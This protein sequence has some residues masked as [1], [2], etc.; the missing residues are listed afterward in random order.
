MDAGAIHKRT[1]DIVAG[2]VALVVLTVGMTLVLLSPSVSAPR[3]TTVVAKSAVRRVPSSNRTVV[4]TL[5]RGRKTR[6]VT[7]QSSPIAA[8]PRQVTTTTTANDRTFVERM[9]GDEGLGFIKLAIVVLAAFLSGALV[10]RAILG[11]YGVTVGGFGLPQLQEAADTSAV[12]IEKLSRSL[13]AQRTALEELSREL[14]GEAKEAR[15]D[16][17]V[18]SE[19]L[20]V[21]YHRLSVAERALARRVGTPAARSSTRRLR[22]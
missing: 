7:R 6:V 9:L 14:R 11:Q 12:A 8:Q 10:Q 20:A 19:D 1:A 15:G 17:A 22:R 3:T 21:I 2:L 18:V 16:L 4:V 13:Q 5:G